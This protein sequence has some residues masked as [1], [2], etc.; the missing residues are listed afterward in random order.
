MS[1]SGDYYAGDNDAIG[2]SIKENLIDSY[3]EQHYASASAGSKSKSV[4]DN[5]YN[6]NKPSL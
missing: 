6:N 1:S 4:S 3:S 2:E 5:N